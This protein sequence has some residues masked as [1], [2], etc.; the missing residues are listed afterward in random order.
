MTLSRSSTSS[1]SSGR[2]GPAVLEADEGIGGVLEEDGGVLD[3]LAE[4]AE[5]G[6]VGAEVPEHGLE[7][8][9]AGDERVLAEV[10]QVEGL[11]DEAGDL[12]GVPEDLPFAEK[13]LVLAGLEGRGLDLLELVGDEV[14]PLLALLL[15]GL[16]LA[17]FLEEAPELLGRAGRLADEAGVVERLVEVG[18]VVLEM[19][20]EDVVV[21]AVDVDEPRGELAEPA[22]RDE[23]AVDEGL[24]RALVGDRALDE[25]LAVLGLGQAG[26][27]EGLARHVEDGL[28]EGLGFA[29]PD[30]LGRSLL[31]QDEADGVDDDGLAGARLAR[32][33]GEAGVEIGP[34]GPRSSPDS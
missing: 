4:L 2:D 1:G 34:R 32:Q 11:V 9:Q 19:E 31:A 15:P 18:E 33:D 30:E 3:A 12:L 5:G 7:P 25:E 24:A 14:E 23:H 26:Q 10:G 22:D 8:G 28:D 29:R 13:A 17:L 16:E 27:V 21:L 20:E 6:L